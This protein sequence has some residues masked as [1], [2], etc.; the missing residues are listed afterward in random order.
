M[1][2]LENGGVTSAKGFSAAATACGL[3]K[4]GKPDLALVVSERDCAAAGVFTQNLV[5]AAP[6]ILDKETLAQNRDSLRAVVINAGNANACTGA[7]GLQNARTTQALVAEAVGCGSEQ[8]LVMSTG[9]IGVPLN[10][11]KVRRGVAAAS[12]SLSPAHGH[13]SAEAIMTTDTRP[14]EVAVQFDT[15]HGPVTIGGMAKG[16][17]MIHPN[18]ATMLAVITTDAAAPAPLLQKWLTQAVNRTF[19][20]ISV[21]GDTSTNDTVLL[22]ANG[23]S[24]VV[25]SEQLPVSAAVSL[26]TPLNPQPALFPAA[27][28]HVCLTLA[29]MIVRDGEGATKVAEIRVTGT[30]ND[31]DAHRIAETIATSP[32]FKTALAGGDANWGR[33]VAAA[34]RAGIPFDPQQTSLT[35]TGPGLEPLTI[36][37]DGMPTRYEEGDAAA[38]FAQTDVLIHLNVGRGSGTDTMWTC[39]FT[40]DYVAINADYRT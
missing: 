37:A 38:I 39:D 15:P 4:N 22:L 33:I 16:A 3:K 12:Q 31:D 11:E 40:A 19:N 27:L 26:A 14:K 23:A 28:H 24:G 36:F 29:Q 10:M 7:E 17:G 21:D 1:R 34:G 18:M 8:V 35:I 9:V 25:I 20:R 30:A 32:L 13:A 5:A 2:L 6:V